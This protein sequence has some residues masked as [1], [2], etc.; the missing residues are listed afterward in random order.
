MKKFILFLKLGWQLGYLNLWRY[1]RERRRRERE[2]GR[3]FEAKKD[4]EPLLRAAGATDDEVKRA[5]E[6]GL[7]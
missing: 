1:E 2:L 4:G 5:K 7:A 6:K 3:V